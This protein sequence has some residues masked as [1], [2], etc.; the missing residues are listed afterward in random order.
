MLLMEG[1]NDACACKYLH[2]NTF[3]KASKMKD[4]GIEFGTLHTQ[5]VF[6]AVKQQ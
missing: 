4:F 6:A 1:G 2:E 3:R 5:Y